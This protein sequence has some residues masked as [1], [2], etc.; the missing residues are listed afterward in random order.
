MLGEDVWREIFEQ[1]VFNSDNE[2]SVRLQS[3]VRPSSC[4]LQC[5]IT[6]LVDKTIEKAFLDRLWQR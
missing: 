4:S 3:F 5:N 6:R 1:F 2:Y